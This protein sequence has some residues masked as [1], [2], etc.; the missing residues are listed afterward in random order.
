MFK[1]LLKIFVKDYE[2]TSDSTVRQRY[3]MLSGILGIVCN[4]FLFALKLTIGL[5]LHSVAVISDAF[6]NLSDMGSTVMCPSA[7]KQHS[8]IRSSAVKSPTGITRSDMA[9]LNIFPH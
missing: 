9:A 5:I 6:N 1:F 2:N 7:P 4:L 3:G 8:L